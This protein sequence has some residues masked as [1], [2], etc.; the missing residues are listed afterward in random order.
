M[1]KDKA[2]KSEEEVKDDLTK[3]E[4]EEGFIPL[5]EAP[6]EV[7]EPEKI[8]DE[9][10]EKPETKKAE[11]K[12]EEPAFKLEP[13][14]PETAPASEDEDSED[15][16]E[17]VY[18]GQVHRLT[19][20]KIVNLAQKGFDY[21]TKVGPHGKIVQMIEAD[22]ELAQIVA[23]HW[24]K[25]TEG[26]TKE[27]KPGDEAQALEVKPM[28]EYDSEVD[29]LKDNLQGVVKLLGATAQK[30]GGDASTEATA[31]QQSPVATMLL[32][33]DPKHFH[34]VMSKFPEYVGR[35]S[36]ADYQRIDSDP[37][38]LCQFYDFVKDQEVE[39]L[40]TTSEGKPSSS[41]KPPFKV[42]SGGGEAPRAS[43]DVDAAWKLSNKDFETQ[44]A[45]VKGYA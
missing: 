41:N 32:T 17:I 7:E 24:K 36:V 31:P 9:E 28:D 25:K 34:H 45:K 13:L 37:A 18:H 39:K 27:E 22:P 42:K 5:P 30:K 11:K 16:I 2:T 21:E 3:A 29:W 20:E 1:P 19:K 38:A 35:L 33:R 15:T 43:D 8:E 10:P 14:Q 26:P 44:L 12:E 40:T 4:E 6:E 23:A